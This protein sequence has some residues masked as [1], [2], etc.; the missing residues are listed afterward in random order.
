MSNRFFSYLQREHERL[1]QAVAEAR[2]FVTSV[3][4]GIQEFQLAIGFLGLSKRIKSMHTSG[5][6]VYFNMAMKELGLDLMRLDSRSPA[7]R[8]Y[9]SPTDVAHQA[10]L[11]ANKSF[12]SSFRAGLSSALCGS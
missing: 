5:Q 12:S 1:E 2:E 10:L 6:H 4:R 11:H 8:M 9:F 7:H 3:L